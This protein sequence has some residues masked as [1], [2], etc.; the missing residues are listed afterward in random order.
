MRGRNWW[1]CSRG[2]RNVRLEAAM[3]SSADSAARPLPRLARI[4]DG[5]VEPLN[6]ERLA[7]GHGPRVP[8]GAGKRGRRAGA[9]A[10]RR[11]RPGHRSLGR[12]PHP[13][14]RGARRAG[15]PRRKIAAVRRRVRSDRALQATTS[16]GATLVANP[17]CYPTAA[18]AGA[19]AARQSRASSTRRAASIVDAKSG[20]SGAGR[21]PSDR[22]HF[23][24]NHGSVAAY[25]VLRP[26]ARRRDGTGAR[27]GRS[28]SC[29]TSCRS[30]A[31]FSRRSTATSAPGTTAEQIADAFNAAYRERAVRPADGRRAAGDQARR[32]D[33]LLRHRLAVRRR[34][35]G[36]WSSWRAST[37]S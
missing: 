1:R 37:T 23:S 33:E 31:A 14:R 30:I 6:T 21:A 34:R 26:S 29:R 5:P 18:L 15:I 10:R 27:R 7:S 11:R 25:G 3:S 35:R 17:G 16:G 8:R 2:T 9:A 36:G 20:I 22:T 4:W 28:R 32:V 13:R 19:P 24:E 12:V